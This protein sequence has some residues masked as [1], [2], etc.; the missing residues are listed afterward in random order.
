[1]TPPAI[2]LILVFCG[3]VELGRRWWRAKKLGSTAEQQTMEWVPTRDAKVVVPNKDKEEWDIR[4]ATFLYQTRGLGANPCYFEA[5]RMPPTNATVS[6]A[7]KPLAPPMPAVIAL[8]GDFMKRLAE[9]NGNFR[10]SSECEVTADGVV[11]RS[12]GNAGGCLFTVSDIFWI[13]AADVE[14]SG[15]VCVATT[16]STSKTYYLKKADSQWRIVGEH[17]KSI[18]CG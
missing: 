10:S 7:S 5:T 13:S 8:P 12:T 9:K 4:E 15:G 16:A 11:D 18:S 2:A 6:R 17:L 3:L 14:L 1:V